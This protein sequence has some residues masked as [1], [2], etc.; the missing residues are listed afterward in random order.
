MKIEV[1]S[2]DIDVD[3]A[4]AVTIRRKLRIALTRMESHITSISMHLSKVSS[5]E[6]GNEKHCLLKVSLVEKPDA[7]IED[8][9]SDLSFVIDRVIQKASRHISR[10]LTNNN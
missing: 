3:E 2:S 9:Q 1:S 8:I 5:S 7:I 10:K 6:T 4:T